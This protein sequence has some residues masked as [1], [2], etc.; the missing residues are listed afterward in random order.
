V[1]LIREAIVNGQDVL[2]LED[3]EVPELW[4]D[5]ARMERDVSHG[6]KEDVNGLNAKLVQELSEDST[7]KEWDALCTK[8]DREDG[9]SANGSDGGEVPEL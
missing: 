4:R 6:D 5:S 3:T 2:L 8:E 1:L 9:L 7:G